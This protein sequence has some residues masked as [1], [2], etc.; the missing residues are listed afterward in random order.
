VG[1]IVTKARTSPRLRIEAAQ[2]KVAEARKGLTRDVAGVRLALDRRKATWIVAGGLA[3]GLA[4]GA[5]PARL[6]SRIG[7]LAGTSVAL[8]ARSVLAPMIAGAILARERGSRV[9]KE[10]GE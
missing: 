8:V 6:W 10:A 4:L 7:A 3:S 9:P 2:R 5:L 1:A